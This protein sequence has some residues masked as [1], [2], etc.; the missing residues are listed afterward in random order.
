MTQ[1]AENTFA[2]QEND[3]ESGDKHTIKIFKYNPETNTVTLVKEFNT[4]NSSTYEYQ[5]NKAE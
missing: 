5:L 2:L 4:E 1:I 3:P